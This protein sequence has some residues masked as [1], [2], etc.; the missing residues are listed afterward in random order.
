MSRLESGNNSGCCWHK[1]A[2]SGL[3]VAVT[4][5]STGIREAITARGLIARCK[6]SAKASSGDVEAVS[7]RFVRVVLAAVDSV[8]D[9]VGI[10]ILVVRLTT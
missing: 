4:S 6:T 2:H 7:E 3:E 10:G 5:A 9:A 1:R 8:G